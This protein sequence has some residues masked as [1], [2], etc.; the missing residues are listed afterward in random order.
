MINRLQG[1]SGARIQV[2]PGMNSPVQRITI[3]LQLNQDV[4]LRNRKQH[5]VED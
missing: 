5:T 2:A 1:E 4:V 3:T